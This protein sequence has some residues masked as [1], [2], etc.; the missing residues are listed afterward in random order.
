VLWETKYITEADI[1]FLQNKPCQKVDIPRKW[2]KFDR[3][4]IMK[5]T[6]DNELNRSR[7]RQSL[8]MSVGTMTICAHPEKVLF[9]W[10]SGG[11]PSQRD[12]RV[13]WQGDQ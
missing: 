5:G 9:Q 12:S 4:T 6:T 10:H 7:S 8:R 11:C 3:A 1:K 13:L 2:M